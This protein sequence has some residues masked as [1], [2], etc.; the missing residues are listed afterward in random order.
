LPTLP[1]FI[2][3]FFFGNVTITNNFGKRLESHN[4]F[5]C[6]VDMFPPC[7]FHELVDKSRVLASRLAT[8]SVFQKPGGSEYTSPTAP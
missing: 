5:A 1:Q 8:L 6:R 4:S 7:F 2:G 3:Q